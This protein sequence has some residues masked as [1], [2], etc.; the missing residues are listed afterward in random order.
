MELEPRRYSVRMVL[1][2]AEVYEE[3]NTILPT[4]L[5]T[6]WKKHTLHRASR[7]ASS[8]RRILLV[9][10]S[11]TCCTFFWASSFARRTSEPPPAARLSTAL[12]QNEANKGDSQV[13]ILITPRNN[14]SPHGPV[15]SFF[16][17]L[18]NICNSKTLTIQYIN[19]LNQH[20]VPLKLAQ[21]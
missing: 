4:P 1:M 21:C 11:S 9:R 14:K 7:L 19:V 13:V 20:V 16:F 8:K 5:W 3:R 10:R 12:L 2:S 15:L 18:I 17:I 6:H